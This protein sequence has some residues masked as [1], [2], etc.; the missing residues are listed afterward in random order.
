LKPKHQKLGADMAGRVETIGSHVKEFQPGDEVFE[1]IAP[2]GNGAFSEYTA[3]PE[4]ALVQKPTNLSFEEAAV[5][6]VAA[7]TALQGLHDQGQI[8]PGKKV[9][10]QGAS[11]GVGT[12]AVQIAKAFG[13]EVTVI[14]S[15]RK[16]DQSR[17]RGADQVSDYTQEDFT[18]KG[19]EYDLIL[20]VNGYHP[21]SAYQRV[22]TPE[23]IYVMAGGSMAQFF[24]AMLL[25]PR[26]SKYE[27]KKFKGVSVKT[28]QKDLA[29]M[30]E[31][32]EARRIKSVIDRLYL[33]SET[34]EALRYLGEGHTLG[35]VVITVM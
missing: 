11:G 9:L 15:T 12:F 33:V 27:G 22:L 5:V 23:G 16:I 31:L 3:V 8:Q 10:I 30:K 18:M 26:L 32:L 1:D 28:N 14:C 17:S 4:H 24:Q 6:P 34:A 35:K 25:G 7:L 13:A 2:W 20:G 21:I 29:F 19:Q